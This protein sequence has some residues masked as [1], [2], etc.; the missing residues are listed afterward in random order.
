MLESLPPELQPP[1]DAEER[2]VAAL[3]RAGVL[4]KQKRRV[5]ALA[6]AA[7]AIVC[8]VAGA[9]AGRRMAAPAAV[10]EAGDPRAQYLLLLYD[11]PGSET[12]PAEEA[13]RVSEYSAWAGA[14]AA[15]QSL[16]GAEKLRGAEVTFVRDREE[17]REA[18]A[19]APGGLLG[20]FFLVRA[21]TE[22]EALRIAR[23]CPHLRH[24]GRVVL[25]PVEPTRG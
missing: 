18:R 12:P 2:T 6:A 9:A 22:A 17:R 15:S 23:E 7:A 4:G 19:N 3:R 24:G 5:N 20:G 10:V 25:R 14:L 13:A 8:L 16:V 1:A 21:A 11:D